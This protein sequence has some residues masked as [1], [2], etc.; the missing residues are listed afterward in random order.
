M[1]P[2]YHSSKDEH[3]R[4]EQQRQESQ[5]LKISTPSITLRSQCDRKVWIII[6]G[7]IEVWKIQ[8]YFPR[9]I[10]GV[11]GYPHIHRVVSS[12]TPLVRRLMDVIIFRDDMVMVV[13]FG[14]I[15]IC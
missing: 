3:C 2:H 12:A 11:K 5:E 9:A 10:E 15:L 14:S 1:S 6:E 13:M 8:Q 4:D 7:R